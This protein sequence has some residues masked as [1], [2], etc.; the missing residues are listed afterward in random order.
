M[1]NVNGNNYA[2]SEALLKRLQMKNL[3]DGQAKQAAEK[4][5]EQKEETAPTVEFK[6]NN[7]GSLDTLD[8]QALMNSSLVQNMKTSAGQFKTYTLSSKGLKVLKVGNKEVLVKGT[9]SFDIA[10]NGN[11]ITIK[12]G[13]HASNISFESKSGLNIIVKKSDK[14]PNTKFNLTT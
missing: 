2:N 6:E 8:Y 7:Q 13:K 1:T 5:G 10:I 14:Y 9:G 12:A 4:T 3:L 11:S